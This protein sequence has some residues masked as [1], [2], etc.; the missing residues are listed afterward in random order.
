MKE[1]LSLFTFAI[2]A[3]CFVAFVALFKPDAISAVPEPT[4]L[5]HCNTEPLP[6]PACR[7]NVLTALAADLMGRP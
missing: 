7:P 3:L 4:R 1:V 5:A 6:P 2:G